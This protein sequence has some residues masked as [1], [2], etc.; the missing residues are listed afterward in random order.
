MVAVRWVLAVVGYI[1]LLPAS[2]PAAVIMSL[3]TRVQTRYCDYYRWGWIFGTFDNPPQGDQGWVAKRSPFPNIVTG[4]RGYINR[5]GWLWRNKLYGYKRAVSIE[6]DGKLLISIKGN[7]DISDKHQR[8]GWMHASARDERGRLKAFEWY[9]VTPY[10]F[11]RCVRI[12]LGWKI[13]GRKFVKKGD[14]APLVFTFNPV[15]GYGND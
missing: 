9:S 13:K 14:F 4:W 7:P 11:G 15:D 5:V 1:L 12:R 2:Y 6:H 3:F 8:A 10:G